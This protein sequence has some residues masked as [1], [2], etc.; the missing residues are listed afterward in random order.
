MYYYFIAFAIFYF[1]AVKNSNNITQRYSVTILR[2]INCGYFVYVSVVK[3][4]TAY[5]IGNVGTLKLYY[6]NIILR[7]YE[8]N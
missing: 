5:W 4:Y 8:N 3:L 7:R 2:R 6:Y 1:L